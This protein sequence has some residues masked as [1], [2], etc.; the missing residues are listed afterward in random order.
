MSHIDFWRIILQRFFKSQSSRLLWL[1]YEKKFDV[2]GALQKVPSDSTSWCPHPWKTLSF[3]VWAAPSGLILSDKHWKSD[4]VTIPPLSYMPMWLSIF[5]SHLAFSPTFAWR[6]A[7][8]NIIGAGERPSWHMAW[9]WGNLWSAV[10]PGSNGLCRIEAEVPWNTDPE[11]T[12]PLDSHR[13]QQIP[14]LQSW[15]NLSV[16]QRSRSSCTWR[17]EWWWMLF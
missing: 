7:S 1:G 17:K 4:G 9:N 16:K 2:V 11:P 13:F 10:G 6:E 15:E 8:C 14:E 12:E 5:I 3:G